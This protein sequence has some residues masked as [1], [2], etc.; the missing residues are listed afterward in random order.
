MRLSGTTPARRYE[1]RIALI[2]EARA[3]RIIDGKT[4]RPLICSNNAFRSDLILEHISPSIT[5]SPSPCPPGRV[6]IEGSGAG[7]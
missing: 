6:V 2:P 1:T 7:S 4:D 3:I 5:V